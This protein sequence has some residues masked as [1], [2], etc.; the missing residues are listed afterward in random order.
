MYCGVDWCI[1]VVVGY[2]YGL[3]GMDFWY[4]VFGDEKV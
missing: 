1:V 3:V 2:V 4:Y